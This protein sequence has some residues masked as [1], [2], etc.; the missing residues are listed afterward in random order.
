[1]YLYSKKILNATSYYELLAR[2][3]IM[4]DMNL[5]MSRLGLNSAHLLEM[6]NNLYNMTNTFYNT[7]HTQEPE[8]AQNFLI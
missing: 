6:I 7:N 4:N 3:P 8:Q 2:L 1:M 5:L